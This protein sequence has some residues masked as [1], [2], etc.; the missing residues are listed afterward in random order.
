M[1]NVTGANLD[2]I[3]GVLLIGDSHHKAGLACNVDSNGGILSLALC[4]V[5][6]TAAVQIDTEGLPDTGLYTSSWQTGVAAPTDDLDDANDFQIAAKNAL[7]DRHYAYYRTAALDETPYNANM[8]D[9]ARIR[10]K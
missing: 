3:K 5:S 2:A 6:Y 7:F 8:R 1:S 4:A 10:L 9:W